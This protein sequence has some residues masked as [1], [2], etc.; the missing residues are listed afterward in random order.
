MLP[1]ALDTYARVSGELFGN[2]SSA[3]AFG[4]AAAARL[5]QARDQLCQACHFSDG[6]LLLVSGGT[7]ANN[8]VI[9]GHLGYQPGARLLL[10]VDT[11]PSIWFA[12]ERYPEQWDLLPLGSGGVI[13][14]GTVA[15]ALRPQTTMVCMSHVCNETG[16]VHQVREIADLCARKGVLLLCDG[17]QA[18]GHVPVDLDQIRC[19]FYTF[20]A[21]KLGG[22]RAVGGVLLRHD[23]LQ[24]LLGGGGQE[25]G[26]RPGTENLAGLAATATALQVS[27][28]QMEEEAQRLRK[29]SRFLYHYLDSN[30]PDLLLNSDLDAGLPGLLSISIPGLE[31]HAAVI[32]LDLLGF[33]VAAGSACHA[34]QKVPSRAILARGYGETEA[35]GTLRISMGTDTT[36]EGVFQLGLTLTDLVRR[37]RR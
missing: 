20:S 5:Q 31:A 10:A 24:P 22:P 32:E 18:L 17:A 29:L 9:R 36:E 2:P 19:D 21:H 3:H 7:E 30:L 4:A 35:L 26:L 27:L 12:S 1:Q 37:Q 34:N 28:E 14:A 8:L 11:H 23:R 15:G 16:T 33:A 25:W 13:D 6:R